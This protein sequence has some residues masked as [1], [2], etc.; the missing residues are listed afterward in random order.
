MIMSSFKKTALFAS[1]KEID[2]RFLY[3]Y[4]FQLLFLVI[5]YLISYSA[6]WLFQIMQFTDKMQQS[7]TTLS[8]GGESAIGPTYK[9]LLGFLGFGIIYILII[10][11]SIAV[12]E[13]L[14]YTYIQNKKIDIKGVL[15]SILLLLGTITGRN[16][17]RGTEGLFL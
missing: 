1:F 8:L 17:C 10:I 6:G 15:K 9:T 2:L 16:T 7:L 13:Y 3:M 4:F 14:M 11:I 12:F 5:L